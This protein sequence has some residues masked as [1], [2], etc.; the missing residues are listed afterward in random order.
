ML[1]AV[2]ATVL[3]VVTV[4]STVSLS[5]WLQLG[6]ALV[7]SGLITL[8]I[9]AVLQYSVFK[10]LRG[11][12]EAVQFIS[13]GSDVSKRVHLPHYGEFSKLAHHIN[14]MLDALEVVK[15]DLEDSKTRYA[16]ATTG[17][18]DGLWDW[19]LEKKTM[20][21]S[22][23]WYSLLG[24]PEE[25]NATIDTWLARVHPDDRERVESHLNNHLE[26]HSRHFESEHRLQH[27]DGSYRWMLVR[28]KAIRDNF[29]QAIRMAGSLTDMR[30]RGMFDTLTGLPNRALLMDRLAHAI[31]RN[32]RE[33][34]RAAVLVLDLN[35]FKVVNDSLGHYVGDLLLIEVSNR[36][37]Q[38]LR[39]GDTVARLGADEFVLLLENV[40]DEGDIIHVI[41]R[42]ERTLSE[43]LEVSGH[44]INTG[45]SLGVV[46]DLALYTKADEVLRN[47]EI[48]MYSAKNA[49]KLYTFFEPDMF[50]Q[51]IHQRQ[52][53][54]EL[55]VALDKGEF[56][57]LYQP[58]VSLKDNETQGFEALL[59]WQ[60]PERGVVSPAEFI[61]LA[62]ET[63][64]IVPL[65]MWVLR[66]ACQ[67]LSRMQQE[68]NMFMS[69]NVSA[70]QLEQ[71]DFMRQVKAVLQETHVK[72]SHLKIEITESAVIANPKLIHTVLSQLKELGIH[73]CMD[74]FGT[75]YSSLSHLHLL[76][77]DTLKIDR[78]FISNLQ[79]DP[80][81][82]AI[83]R[84]MTELANHLGI[85]V[86]SEGVEL[87][88]QAEL[89]KHLNCGYAQGYFFSRPVHLQEARGVKVLS[90]S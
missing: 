72:A 81:S 52:I 64:L 4:L 25:R 16:L 10:P 41:E 65:G 21:Y 11:L 20:F 9:R 68:T 75:G 50:T 57:L 7:A 44:R 42:L 32:A 1:V 31:R 59:R 13:K 90:K 34:K 3:L 82:L 5:L 76:P 12:Q 67:Q 60:H 56:F 85:D 47:A 83:V 46:P 29:D 35:R 28:G 86:V 80:N 38:A 45:C 24:Q 62:E 27:H 43:P 55:K 63:G 18:N 58:I 6:L 15:R 54:T 53:E 74:D 77:L 37:Q 30:G 2:F 79:H 36:L 66:E 48:A 69:V 26:G 88:E 14:D 71:L 19:D 8:G 84:T 87:L 40:N 23:R 22:A 39:S 61:P 70:R 49:A 73:I 51:V 33:H 89:L 17:A 78:S